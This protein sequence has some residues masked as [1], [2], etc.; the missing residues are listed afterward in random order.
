[1]ATILKGRIPPEWLGVV[2]RLQVD[3]GQVRA[4]EFEYDG[5]IDDLG[6]YQG[7]GYNIGEVIYIRVVDAEYS[8]DSCTYKV[9]LTYIRAN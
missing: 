1:M 9:P 6:E 8:T 7:R 5:V 3:F 4:V 2:R